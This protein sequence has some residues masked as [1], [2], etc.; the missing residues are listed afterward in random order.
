MAPQWDEARATNQLEQ[1]ADEDFQLEP[2]R[3]EQTPFYRKELVSPLSFDPPTSRAELSARLNLIMGRTLG[4][5]AALAQVEVPGPSTG[6]GFAGQLIELF[7]GA[8]A[9]NLPVPDF[10]ELGIELKTLSLSADLNLKESTYIC[11]ADLKPT[12]F[13]PFEQSHLYHKLRDLLLVLVLAP[14]ELPLS[15]RPVVGYLFYQPTSKVWAQMAADYNEFNELICS[16][17]ST[18]ITGSMGTILQLRPKALNSKITTLVRNEHGDLVAAT[19]KAYY[20]RADF[21]RKILARF[22]TDLGL[23]AQDLTHLK[24]LLPPPA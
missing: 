6:K 16:G 8:N 18:T 23:G 24:A 9:R 3:L 22:L 10:M 17:H 1:A 13:V 20:L 21:T 4:E 14:P 19:P 12:H 2:Q 7:L 15:Q 5:L 11:M